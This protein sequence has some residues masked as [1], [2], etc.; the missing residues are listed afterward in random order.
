MSGAEL[1]KMQD[2]KKEIRSRVEG[3]VEKLKEYAREADQIVQASR[4]ESRLDKDQHPVQHRFLQ[5]QRLIREQGIDAEE[6]REE[7]DEDE[8]ED[9][10]AQ[11]KA[12]AKTAMAVHQLHSFREAYEQAEHRMREKKDE[13][14]RKMEEVM[15]N[16]SN[17]S[18]RSGEAHIKGDLNSLDRRLLLQHWSKKNRILQEYR[19]AAGLICLRTDWMCTTKL[20][21]HVDDLLKFSKE[22]I[23]DIRCDLGK[24]FESV[25]V[26]VIARAF[27]LG[28]VDNDAHSQERAKQQY[29]P[30]VKRGVLDAVRDCFNHLEEWKKPIFVLGWQKLLEKERDRTALL[31]VLAECMEHA[32]H[33]GQ[34]KV[35]A[36]QVV[37]NHSAQLC[38]GWHKSDDG[39]D[40]ADFDRA[41]RRFYGFFEDYLDDHKERA[42]S[43]AFMEPARYYA[44]KAEVGSEDNVSTHAINWH[45]AMLQSTL[46]VH[47][48]LIANYDDEAGN[49]VADFWAG[50]QEGAWQVFRAP[51]HF[52]KGW[53]S[54]PTFKTKSFV[55]RKLDSHHFPI[56]PRH[57]CG[58]PSRN[59]ANEAVNPDWDSGKRRALAR[60]LER[61]AYFFSRGFFV[62]KAIETL[63]SETKPEHCGFRQVCDTLFNVY[64][65]EQKEVTADSFVEH[66]Y[67]DEL[68][69]DFDTDHAA[70][71]LAWLGVLR[72]QAA[73]PC[74]DDASFDWYD[75]D[76]IVE[77]GVSRKMAVAFLKKADG[78]AE[79]AIQ[80]VQTYKRMKAVMELAKLE[81]DDEGRSSNE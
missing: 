26:K 72:P 58:G 7:A 65:R 61:F 18:I 37:M 8:E 60:Y 73:Q 11:R 53:R 23:A 40:L 15:R 51:E 52:G 10:E 1:A 74:G 28:D 17:W 49:F 42:F 48:P 35:K 44:R 45:L 3:H 34:V 70:H 50:L 47:V 19:R 41:L 30:Y 80:L 31:A 22:Q 27:C 56:E 4:V 9:V 36:F 12:C 29:D 21:R 81:E 76:R 46:S 39:E 13:L 2:R 67:R 71:F 54:I 55:K 25:C 6:P 38:G 62:R 68:Y 78:D 75:V 63:N 57:H 77:A 66:I 20:L 64:R 33:C 43:S 32:Q 24:S 14:G 79:E 59:L 5:L 16:G 69:T